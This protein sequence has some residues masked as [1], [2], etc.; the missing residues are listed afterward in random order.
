MFP[1]IPFHFHSVRRKVAVEF[2]FSIVAERG[3]CSQQ[4]INSSVFFHSYT[5]NT[6]VQ[7]G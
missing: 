1:K 7:T 3:P 2:D 6:G 5:G 4:V